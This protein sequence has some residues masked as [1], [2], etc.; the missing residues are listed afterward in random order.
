MT[1]KFKSRSV[2]QF[3]PAALM[4][5]LLAACGGDGGSSGSSMSSGSGGGIYG[6][7]G[8]AAAAITISLSNANI[9]VGQSSTLTWSVT[10]ATACTASGDWSGSEPVTGSKTLSPTAAGTYT[11]TLMCTGS[12]AA[13]T[14]STTLTAGAAAAATGPYT[15]TSLVANVAGTSALTVDTHLV[16]P[17]GIVFAPNAPVW[18]ANNGSSTSTLYDGSGNPQPAASPLVVTFA[19]N[20]GRAFGPTGIVANTTTDFAVS[21]GGKS[22][23]ASFIYVGEAGTIA[24]W[25]STVNSTAAITV[26]TDTAGA[27]Y[28]GAALAS[29][30]GQNYLYAADFHNNKIDVFNGTFVKQTPSAGSFAFTDPTLPAGYA[31]FGIQAIANGSGGA[32]QI[33]VTYA[34]QKAPDNSLA[35]PGAGLGLV[36]VFDAS[37]ALVT[38]LIVTGGALNAPWGIALAPADFGPF[39]NDLLIGNLGDGKI[40]AF[41]AATGKLVGPIS[42]SHSNPIAVPGLWGIAFGNDSASQPQNTLFFAAGTNEGSDG[43]YGR[44]DVGA[45]P[46]TLNGTAPV[47]VVAPSATVSGTVTLTAQVGDSVSVSQVEF[48]AGG[49]AIGTANAAPFTVQWNTQTSANGTV[50]LTATATEAYGKAA[51]SAPVTV[52]VNNAAPAATLT[53]LQAQV[54]GPICSGC[55][56]GAGTSLPGVQNLTSAAATYAALVNVA[57]IEQPNLLRVKPGDPTDSYVIH[58]IEGLAGITGARMPFG[59]PYLSTATMDQIESWIAAGAKND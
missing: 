48:F 57:S 31:P 4:I 24:G 3:A 46:P 38:H 39:S 12:G 27:E 1:Y 33:Y 25:S 51:N 52:T 22:G 5:M 17:W 34:Q 40:N 42:D 30:G 7:G 45:T 2:L 53:Q 43:E 56:N 47:T 55:H 26:Y 14:K 50:T 16:N 13:A 41:D 29:T 23:A 9:Q 8:A 19:A 28:T 10:N 54:F 59:G 36:D 6:G 15:S 11:Y 49:K 20:A 32:M 35:A 58:K 21:S 37:G 18:I 44:I